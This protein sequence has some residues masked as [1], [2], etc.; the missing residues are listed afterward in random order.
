MSRAMAGYGRVQRFDRDAGLGEL[1][2]PDGRV[3]PFHC[4]EI[5]D[6]SRE[7][8]IGA[9]VEFRLAA[10]HRGTWEAKAVTTVA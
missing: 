10:G 4:T 7:V 1:V 5:V 3:L 6:G 9:E 8:A 2:T